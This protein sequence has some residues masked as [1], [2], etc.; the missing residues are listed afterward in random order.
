MQRTG[1]A[2]DNAYAE[3][4][5]DRAGVAGVPGS[6]FGAPAHMRFSF[7]TSREMLQQALDRLGTALGAR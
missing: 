2:D 3:F 1:H 7:A 5:L 6:G 4:L